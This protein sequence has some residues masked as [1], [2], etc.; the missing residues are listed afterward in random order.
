[1]SSMKPSLPSISILVMSYNQEAFIG[2]CVDSVLSQ[3]Y[4]GELEFIFCDDNSSDT[5]F[6]IIEDKV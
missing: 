3:E 6:K 5:T 1:M 4:D 2:A